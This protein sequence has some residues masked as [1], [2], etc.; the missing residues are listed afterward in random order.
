MIKHTQQVEQQESRT[1][2]QWMIKVLAGIK[3]Y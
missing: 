2:R 3:G 1:T